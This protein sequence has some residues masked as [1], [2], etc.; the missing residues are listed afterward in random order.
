M[1]ARVLEAV[2]V[3]PWVAVPVMMTPPVGAS[4]ILATACVAPLVTISVVL[5]KSL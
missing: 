5:C 2:R 4:L 3:W 1:S